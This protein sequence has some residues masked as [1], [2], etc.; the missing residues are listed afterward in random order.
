MNPVHV[1]TALF[2]L[3]VMFG[4]LAMIVNNPAGS[5]SLVAAGADSISSITKSLEGR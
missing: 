3:A 4:A 1:I 2:G 5:N